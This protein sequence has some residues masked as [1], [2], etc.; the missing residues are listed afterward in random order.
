MHGGRYAHVVNGVQRDMC[1]M[2]VQNVSVVED[3]EDVD[4]TIICSTCIRRNTGAIS[5]GGAVL[6]P[7]DMDTIN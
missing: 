3:G 2:H 4:T 1:D 6:T 5:T 7:G